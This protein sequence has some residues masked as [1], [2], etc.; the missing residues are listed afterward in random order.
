LLRIEHF[1]ATLP[2][3]SQGIFSI[4]MKLMQIEFWMND[5]LPLDGVNVVHELLK[6]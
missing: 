2:K 1:S 3:K 6:V 5:W 4:V